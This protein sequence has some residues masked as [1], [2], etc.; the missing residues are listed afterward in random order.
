MTDKLL[1]KNKKVISGFL[2]VSPRTLDRYVKKYNLNVFTD[3]GR[4]KLDLVEVIRQ[5][6]S[7]DL[8]QVETE[9][10]RFRQFEDKIVNNISNKKSLKGKKTSMDIDNMSGLFETNV[11]GFGRYESFSRQKDSVNNNRQNYNV[12]KSE[13]SVLSSSQE[14]KKEAEIYK[15]LYTETSAELKI[16]QERLE[17]ATYRVGQLEAQIKN[18]VP[19][20]TYRQKEEE[21]IQLQEI[22]KKEAETQF[23]TIKKVEKELY[24]S[25]LIKNVYTAV[26]FAVLISTPL[27]LIYYLNF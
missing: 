2:G 17:G 4:K 22:Q 26:L 19:L 18:T 24:E 10:D 6:N 5:L 23:K 3:K 13:S 1:L 20:L 27:V 16:K 9:L 8:R 7:D 15:K 11:I 14:S 21:V 25:R 12:E